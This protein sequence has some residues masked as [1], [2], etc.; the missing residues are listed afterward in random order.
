MQRWKNDASLHSCETVKE[1]HQVKKVLDY[2]GIYVDEFL[3]SDPIQDWESIER[4]KELWW[5]S[6]N[7][8]GNKEASDWDVLDCG[9]K[10]GQFPEYLVDRVKSVIG[11]EISQDYVKY[12]AEKGRPIAYGDVCN[13]KSEWTDKFDCVFSHHLLGLVPDYWKALEEMLRV[14]KPGGY[15]ITCNDVPG[16]PRKHYSFIE[17]DEIFNDF[18]KE[19]DVQQI[20]SGC[21]NP[22]FPK[23]W[24]YII[25]K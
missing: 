13:M 19:K 4:C 24:V 9:S 1:G 2:Y 7:I 18:T 8:L 21:W 10:D 20:F 6:L 12:A 11:I 14:A 16:N 22:I 17:D 5:W 3:N 23:E 15:L 25:E